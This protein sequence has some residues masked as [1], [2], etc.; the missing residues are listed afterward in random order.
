[1]KIQVDSDIFL[2]EFI[3]DCAFLLVY[4]CLSPLSLQDFLAFVL[5]V[6][7]CKLPLKYPR[8]GLFLRNLQLGFAS[9]NEHPNF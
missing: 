1:M 7:T 8:P 6:K 9:L 3:L 5:V 4:I 2:G